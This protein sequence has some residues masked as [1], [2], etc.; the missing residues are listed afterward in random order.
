MDN[1]KWWKSLKPFRLKSNWTIKWNKLEDIEPDEIEPEDE[2]WLYIFVQD[3]T[4]LVTEY[5]YK[6]NKK[7]ITHTLAIDLGWYPEGDVKGHYYLIAILDDDWN[8]PIL[9]LK[10]RNT[11]EV[12]D[13]IEQWSFETFT[14][15]FWKD[16]RRGKYF[17]TLSKK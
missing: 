2:A 12:A 16:V 9:E 11:Q 4:Y 17:Q 3:M 13:T 8:N 6:E 10:T 15:I 14:D 7:V 1:K 5:T